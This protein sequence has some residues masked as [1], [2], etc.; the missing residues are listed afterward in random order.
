MRDSSQLGSRGERK[1]EGEGEREAGH[2]GSCS[3]RHRS[4]W[5]SPGSR[6]PL[7]SCD[8]AS[9]PLQMTGCDSRSAICLLTA[10]DS[11]SPERGPSG[12][13]GSSSLTPLSPGRVVAL[14][15][16]FADLEML[17]V[18]PKSADSSTSPFWVGVSKRADNLAPRETA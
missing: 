13:R 3:A 8:V 5:V 10:G 7:P 17:P 18:S 6:S 11:P 2:R 12:P 16:L 1:R 14:S 9:Q 15:G 4:R